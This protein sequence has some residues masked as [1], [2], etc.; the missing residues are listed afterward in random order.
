MFH[1][2]RTRRWGLC[3]LFF[4]AAALP[5]WADDGGDQ[6]TITRA[7]NIDEASVASVYYVTGSIPNGASAGGLISLSG[8]GMFQLSKDWGMDVSLPAVLI[9]EPLFQG[10]AV[11]API[12]AGPRWVFEKF[13]SENGKVGGLFSVEG[14]AFYWATPDPDDRFPGVAS[15]YIFQLLGAVR[16]GRAYL[17]GNYG[18]DG[19]FN[20]SFTAEWFAFTSLGYALTSHWCVQMEGDYTRPVNAGAVNQ[21]TFVPQVGFKDGG[22]LFELGLAVTTGQTGT[23]TDFVIEKN[24]F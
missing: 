18:Y 20:S 10:P 8:E 11:L 17:Q 9:D 4:I 5:L 24:L 7:I 6:P 1:R 19:A 14:Q 16:V 21:L 2:I 22:W 3:F 13:H 12:G 23:F 15:N